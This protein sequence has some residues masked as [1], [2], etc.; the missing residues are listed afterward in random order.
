[1]WILLH[2]LHDFAD[3]AIQLGLSLV[4]DL[5]HQILLFDKRS[6]KRV[7]LCQQIL[8]C[9]HINCFSCQLLVWL[10]HRIITLHRVVVIVDPFLALRRK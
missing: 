8:R 6:G 2:C 9:S 5:N 10:I 3:I 1:M 4:L 7:A